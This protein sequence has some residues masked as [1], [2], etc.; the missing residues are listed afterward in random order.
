[1]NPKQFSPRLASGMTGWWLCWLLVSAVAGRA[2]EAPVEPGVSGLW[3]W[4]LTSQNGQTIETTVR[5]KAEEG[6][7]TGEMPAPREREQ[8]TPIKDGKVNGEEVSFTL[9]KERDGQQY[10][11]TYT[12][13]LSGNTLKGRMQFVRDGETRS[14]S[15]EATRQ[16]EAP[17]ARPQGFFGEWKYSV[18]IAEGD[19]LDLSLNLRREKDEW[20]GHVKF[21]D[22]K[23][24]ISDVQKDGA[25]I[26]F[27]VVWDRDGEK[28]TSKYSGRRDGDTIKGKIESDYGGQNRT[29]E[30]LAKRP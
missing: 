6:K 1:M 17:P 3:M 27:K 22:L 2:A 28:Y 10:A 23:L 20:I 7:L 4:S 12:G 18:T 25:D 9:V 30:W 21:G 15:W 24:P 8:P 5:L 19:K 11:A 29:F 16:K 14:R 13:K 26:S